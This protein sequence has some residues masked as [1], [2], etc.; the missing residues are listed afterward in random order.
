MPLYDYLCNCGNKPCLVVSISDR[1]NQTCEICG[2]TMKRKLSVPQKA[3]IKKTGS[4]MTLNTLN[5]E[6][7]QTTPRKLQHAH[8][9]MGGVRR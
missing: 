4:E 5:K 6:Y 9:A 7:S 3:I 8:G 2:A 1:D